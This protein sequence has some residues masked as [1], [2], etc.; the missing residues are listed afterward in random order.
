M[1]QRLQS[2]ALG[3]DKESD[4]EHENLLSKFGRKQAK[5]SKLF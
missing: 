1:P 5:T 3:F 2:I 4:P